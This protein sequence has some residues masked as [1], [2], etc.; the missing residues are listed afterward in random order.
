MPITCPVCQTHFPKS[1]TINSRHKAKCSGEVS[2]KPLP[3]LCGHEATSLTQMKRHRVT[4]AVWKARDRGEV[5]M[6]RLADTFAAKHGEGISHPM[7][8]LEVRERAAE[9]NRTR[10]GADNVFSRESSLFGKVQESLEGKRPIFR[11]AENAFA[12]PEVKAKIQQTYFRKY[13][14]VNPQQVP[15]IRAKTQET[16]L[17]RYGTEEVLGAPVIREKIVTT[18][19]DRYGGPAPSCSKEIQEQ[20]RQTNLN[21]W[22]VP[23]TSMHPTVRQKQYDAM[24][25]KYGSHFFASEEGRRA[26]RDILI[27]KYGVDHPAKIDGFWEKAV[28]TFVRKY[29]A[30]HPLLLAEFLE[31]RSQTCL[32][33]YGVESPLQSPEIFA[34]LVATMQERYGVSYALQAEELKAKAR[35]TNIA[36][37]GVDHPMKNREYAAQHLERMRRPGPNLLER[38]F[39]HALQELL[40]TGDGSFWRWLPKLG[41]HKNPDFIVPGPD[42]EHPKRGV[43]KIV[44]VFGDYWHSKMFTGKA[45]FDHQSELIDAFAE[46]GIECLV[47]WESDFNDR[48]AEVVARVRAFLQ[49]M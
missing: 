21:R 14:V 6:K 32:A 19:Y 28:A 2:T 46:V 11:G 18:N 29:G 12:S 31:K 39:G 10:F 5:Q 36:K 35:S 44:E 48:P 15:E 1:D 8:V 27:A 9:T 38:R 24:Q 37:Y 33:R 25:E 16:N 40:Y 47:I 17:A 3:C 49:A 42:V 20:A 13:G 45:N 22:G 41:Q 23:W 4:C 30:E 43:T 34:K 26:V 7:H